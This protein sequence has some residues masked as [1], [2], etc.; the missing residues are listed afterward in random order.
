MNNFKLNPGDILV[1]VNKR[2][3]PFSRIKRWLMGPFEHC[4]FYLGR[5]RIITSPKQ[6]VTLRF[7]LLFESNGR[8]AVI[9][10]LSNRYGQ[11]VI[12]MR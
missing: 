8:G 7:P 5:V 12:V 10:A 9:Q 1:Q 2:N 4:F 6:H 11:P 3:D